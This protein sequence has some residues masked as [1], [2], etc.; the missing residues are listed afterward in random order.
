M[1]EIVNE[2]CNCAVPGYPC[3]GPSCPRRS[4]EHFKCDKCGAEA[5]LYEIDGKEL[6]A[7]C[8]LEEFPI[9]EG[10]DID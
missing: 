7:E 8:L 2:C 5:T 10:S 3:L 1:R 9:V 6:C 4:V